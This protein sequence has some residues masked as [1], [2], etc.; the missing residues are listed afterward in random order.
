VTALKAV[1]RCSACVAPVTRRVPHCGGAGCRWWRCTACGA[2][3]DDEG[4]HSCG[5]DPKKCKC[6][7]WK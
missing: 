3:N 4:R 1:L 7:E 6:G 5:T 2:A